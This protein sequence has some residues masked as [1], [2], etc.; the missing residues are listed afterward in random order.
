MQVLSLPGVSGLHVMP[1]TKE[2]RNMTEH[3][4]RD[5]ILPNADL[6]DRKD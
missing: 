1:L 6:V 5:G 3:F 2:S 4:L